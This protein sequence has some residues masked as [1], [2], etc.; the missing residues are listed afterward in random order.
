M[1]GKA[2]EAA[3]R[4][5]DLPRGD[6][7]R[8]ERLLRDPDPEEGPALVTAPEE[9]PE[10]VVELLAPPATG[11]RATV[12]PMFEL[13]RARAPVATLCAPPVAV[14]APPPAAVRTVPVAVRVPP[15]RVRAPPAVRMPLEPA[16]RLRDD[17]PGRLLR[18]LRSPI[19]PYLADLNVLIPGNKATSPRIS[20]ILRS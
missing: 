4:W 7:V 13:L 6:G 18:R 3:P 19:A 20:S 5:R 17:L 15:A 16:A 2:P 12:V 14:R 8:D 9:R 1:P 10:V 11:L